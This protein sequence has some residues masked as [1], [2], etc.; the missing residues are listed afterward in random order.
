MASNLVTRIFGGNSIYET[1]RQHETNRDQNFGS[2][3]D[4]EPGNEDGNLGFEDDYRY[5]RF[6]VN[7]RAIPIPSL[8]PDGSPTR[9]FLSPESRLETAPPPDRAASRKNASIND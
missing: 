2:G 7:R 5:S 6:E 3:D 4:L 1:L 8:D 9:A